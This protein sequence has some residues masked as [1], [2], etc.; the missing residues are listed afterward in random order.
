MERDL[1]HYLYVSSYFGLM[2]FLKV[3]MMNI[4]N[5]NGVVKLGGRISDAKGDFNFYSVV[6]FIF[7]GEILR[8]WPYE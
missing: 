2:I 6:K 7:P 3:M 8:P 4:L 1:K 5:Q